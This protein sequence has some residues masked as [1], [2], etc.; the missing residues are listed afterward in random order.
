MIFLPVYAAKDQ[1]YLMTASVDS[2]EASFAYLF[3][4]NE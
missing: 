4:N 1:T 3:L 2:S